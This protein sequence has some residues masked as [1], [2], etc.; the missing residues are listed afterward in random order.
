MG[1]GNGV[2]WMNSGVG[3]GGWYGSEMTRMRLWNERVR[4]ERGGYGKDEKIW[5]G[6]KPELW[7]VDLDRQGRGRDIDD[8]DEKGHEPVD[9]LVH[10][11]VCSY[12]HHSRNLGVKI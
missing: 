9:P 10:Y 12:S 5:D 4:E 1:I 7:E 11:T 2:G 3:G 8:D 6:E